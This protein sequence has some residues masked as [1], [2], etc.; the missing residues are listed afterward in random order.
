[1]SINTPKI[2]LL[3]ISYF[4]IA[5]ISWRKALNLVL[6]RNRAEV[7]AEAGKQYSKV[8]NPSVVRLVVPSPDPYKLFQRQK[9]SKRNLFLRDNFEC[10]YCGKDITLKDG[11]VDHVIPRSKGGKSTYLNCVASCKPCNSKKDSKS[12]AEVNMTLR[13]ELSYPSITDFCAIGKDHA[14]EEWNLFL[15]K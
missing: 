15:R 1:M 13:K 8:F 11:T 14:P 3:N 6:F 2:L 5:V 10:Q 12:L 7:V 4:P 9:F